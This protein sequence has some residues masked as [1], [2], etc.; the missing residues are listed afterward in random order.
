[1]V[2]YGGSGARTNKNET[3]IV[4][5]TLV[6]PDA[7]GYNIYIIEGAK[8]E[9]NNKNVHLRELVD[10][11]RCGQPF[12]VSGPRLVRQNASFKCLPQ[13]RMFHVMRKVSDKT[14]YKWY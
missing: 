10:E 8:G 3:E 4:K 2:A 11:H 7:E 13:N 14:L 1:M 5:N 12:N 9:N 6:K